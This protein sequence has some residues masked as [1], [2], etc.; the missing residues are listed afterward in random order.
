M[1]LFR[2]RIFFHRNKKEKEK[3]MTVDIAVGS[4]MNDVDKHSS[5]KK[6]IY[7]IGT[8][9]MIRNKHNNSLIY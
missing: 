2:E 5:D 8:A 9:M 6:T 3:M 7:V 1:K 4:R